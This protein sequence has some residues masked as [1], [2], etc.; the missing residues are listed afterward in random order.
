MKYD[1]A[2]RSLQTVYSGW[3]FRSRTEARW[4]V[5]FEYLGVRYEYEPQMFMLDGMVYMP[6]FFLPDVKTWVEIKGV[7]PNGEEREKCRRLSVFTKCPVLLFVGSPWFSVARLAF[8]NGIEVGQWNE[9]AE[10]TWRKYRSALSGKGQ[11]AMLQIDNLFNFA[12]LASVDSEACAKTPALVEAYKAARF[13]RFDEPFEKRRK[14]VTGK[15]Q[16]RR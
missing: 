7:A 1:P 12:R 8:C 4:S 2:S 13:E 10:M 16:K 5:F 9:M 6:D 11:I 14:R 15:G 3:F